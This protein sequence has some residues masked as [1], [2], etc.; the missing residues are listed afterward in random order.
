MSFVAKSPF[1]RHFRWV[2]TSENSSTLTKEL[3]K[4]NCPPLHYFTEQ[5][6]KE[7]KKWLSIAR[8]S[9]NIRTFSPFW[10]LHRAHHQFS[11]KLFTF[12]RQITRQVTQRFYNLKFFLLRTSISSTMFGGHFRSILD[13]FARFAGDQQS[14]TIQLSKLS[15]HFTTI[16]LDCVLFHF[17][18]MK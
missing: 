1:W 10:H 4:K 14:R 5:N 11:T 18:Q 6:S 12:S 17:N 7:R 13:T 2:S 16:T 9:R 15:L 8:I 3:R